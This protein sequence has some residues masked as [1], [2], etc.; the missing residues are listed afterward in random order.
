MAESIEDTNVL[1]KKVL[2]LEKKLSHYEKLLGVNEYDPVKTAFVVLVKMLNQQTNYLNDF[3]IKTHIASSDKESPE[4]KRSM[5]MI[6]G[7]PK[8]I[9]AVNDLRATLKLTKE[10]LHQIDGDNNKII[11]QSRIT[12][13]E[14]ISNVLGNTAGQ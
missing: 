8:M 6:D 14:S 7:L 13:P 12:T 3:N 4:Y 10:D 9:T 2:E 11:F 1:N 5:D